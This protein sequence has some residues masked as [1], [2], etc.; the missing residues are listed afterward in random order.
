MKGSIRAF[1][2]LNRGGVLLLS[3]LGLLAAIIL[4]L[5][6]QLT[7]TASAQKGKG[8][9][10]R[11]ESADP[12]LPNY[13][14]R[15]KGANFKGEDIATFFESARN[16]VGKSAVS[17]ADIREGFVRGE[18]ALKARL[19]QVKF[20]YNEDIHIPEVITP[21]VLTARIE[22]LSP[23]S[24]EKRSEIL[25]NFVKENNQLI[26]VDDQQANA[27]KVTADYTNPDGNMS[28]AH[29]EQTINGIPVFRGEV[30][31]GFT[32]D[33]R[34]IRVINNLAPG[35]D[36]GSLSTDF[37][38]PLDAVKAAAGY[39]N[40]DLRAAD[41]SLN[42]KFSTEFKA[43]FGRGDWATTAEKIYFPTE[44]GIA[45]AA[46]RVL[47]WQP[48]NA[49][50]VIVDAET[51][52]MLWRKN[53]ANDQTQPATYN[54]YSNTTSLGKALNS[55]SPFIPGPIDPT[56]HSQAAAVTRSNVVLIGNEGAL[57]FNNLGWMTDGTNGV[58]GTTDGNAVEA[59]L[60]IDGING[61]DPTGKADGTARVFNFAYTPS[62]VTG[63]VP[64][65]T[66]T[67]GG[68]PLNTAVYRNGSTTNL[69]YL[70][71]RYHDALYQV[72]FTEPA[73]NFQN[74]NFGR[75]GSAADRVSA[76]V[77]DSSGTNNANFATPADGGRGRMQMF[78][79]TNGTAPARDGSLDSDVVF[80]ELTHGTS[81]A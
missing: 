25:R 6:S 50:Y 10:S 11:T 49:Y 3:I 64:P 7:K 80:H 26:G 35:L 67:E 33:G 34:M 68:D 20:E 13:D 36:Y 43:V 8:L 1:V 23:P 30:K 45:R 69:F 12:G 28:F 60:D 18:N 27:L 48:V 59:G 63:G 78:V 70:T 21:D 4:L 32:K 52:T 29:L 66:G 54:V 44:P 81:T 46:W 37:R 9:F 55:P 61:V 39:I 72:G 19:P 41:V 2:T 53:I 51:G 40:H 56:S 76:E 62:F 74:D 65:P 15:L 24:N 73:R 77:Q 5:P 16:S 58:N 42:G 22:F 17:V 14:I 71:N 75:G 47:I 38:D 31:A 79:F 57:S